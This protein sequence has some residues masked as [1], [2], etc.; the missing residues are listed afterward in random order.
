[1][2][3]AMEAGKIVFLY[4]TDIEDY[5]KDRGRYFE[6][7]ELPFPLAT[8]NDELTTNI[9][10][11]NIQLYYEQVVAFSKTLGLFEGGHA[12]EEVCNKLE[13]VL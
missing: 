13:K 11:S 10:T 8:N 4:A 6:F 3:D 5:D 12:C 1:M 9:M 2:F 7:S